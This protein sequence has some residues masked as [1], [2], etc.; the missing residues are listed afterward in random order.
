MI[1][2]LLTFSFL[3]YLL[4][5]VSPWRQKEKEEEEEEESESE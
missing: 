2:F 1:F 5:K 4:Y 3:S